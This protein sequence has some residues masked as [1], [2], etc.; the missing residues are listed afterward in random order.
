MIDILDQ[1]LHDEFWRVFWLME[2][3]GLYFCFPHFSEHWNFISLY[4]K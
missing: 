1:M 4:K 2:Q 3:K